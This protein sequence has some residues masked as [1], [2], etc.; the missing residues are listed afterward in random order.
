MACRHPRPHAGGGHAPSSGWLREALPNLLML[1]AAG[2]S[3][4]WLLASAQLG[5]G[6]P[7]LPLWPGLAFLTPAALLCLACGTHIF[8]RAASGLVKARRLNMNVLVGTAVAASALAGKYVPCLLV[9][10]LITLG[11]LLEH[12]AVGKAR[13]AVRELVELQPLMAWLKVDGR[14]VAVRAEELQPGDVV[15]IRPGDRV[16][17]DG[18]VLS[19][20][21]YVDESAMTGE[22]TPVEKVPGSR[23]LAG[24]LNTSGAVEVR[25]ERSGAETVLAR[26]MRM[27][28]EAQARR[29]AIQSLADR[30]ASAFIVLVLAIAGLTYLATADVNRA[31]SALVVACPCAWALATPAAVAA[32]VGSAARRG[33]L[34][35]GG[36]YLEVIAQVDTVVF[37]K[38]GTLTLGRPSIV[39]IMPLGALKAE[40]VLLLACVA[41]KRSEH[42]V[43]RAILA[44]AQQL[45][46]PDPEDFEDLP[47][48]GVVARYGGRVLAVGTPSFVRQYLVR[49]EVPASPEPPEPGASE[50][51]VA[52][53]GELAGIIYITDPLKEDAR[54]AVLALRELGVKHIVLLTGDVEKA[55]QET[56]EALG[57]DAYHARLLPDEKVEVVRSLKAAGRTV[58]AV[59]DGVNDAPALAEADVG[60]AMGSSGIEI[61][62][63]T[64]DVVLASGKPSDVPRLL[65]LARRAMKV[66][67]QNFAWAIAFNAIAI[68]LAVL[69]LLAPVLGAV[70]HHMS[71]TL[72]VLNSLRLLRAAEG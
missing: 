28:E 29:P 12:R 19:G 37:D 61:T 65:K 66:I 40:E 2:C 50:V 26:V 64:A 6:W 14:V 59:G 9:I 51:W 13:E 27:V 53:D 11:G 52:V 18:V 36:R 38:T 56:A 7:F 72:V 35:K 42:P 47:G 10:W 39:G 41:E 67:K 44:S 33:I 55:A 5:I 31:V 60:V 20:R 63:E 32:S 54:E 22:P 4:A 23:V 34:I 58:L 62:I 24:T 16:P 15:L 21:A 49:Q 8:L 45:E 43:A 48:Q 1:A 3:L 25:V 17:A 30:M 57:L 69:G 68:T 70:L 46:V 71:S